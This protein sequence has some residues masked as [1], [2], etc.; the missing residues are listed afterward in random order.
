MMSDR[1]LRFVSH[2]FIILG[3]IFMTLGVIIVGSLLFNENSPNSYLPILTEANFLYFVSSFLGRSLV[4]F[5]IGSIAAYV[6]RKN[7]LKKL[8]SKNQ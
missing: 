1:Y 6:S 3:V 5:V 2:G 4:F 7:G 8:A